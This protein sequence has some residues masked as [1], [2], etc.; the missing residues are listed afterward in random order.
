M[1]P[2]EA[3]SLRPI[4]LVLVPRAVA[5]LASRDGSSVSVPHRTTGSARRLRVR[6]AVLLG[7][8]EPVQ[9]QSDA[10]KHPTSP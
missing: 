7:V 2:P 8:G 9:L 1:T 3:T 6:V 4:A 10:L 5:P